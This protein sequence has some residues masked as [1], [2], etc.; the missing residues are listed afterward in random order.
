MFAISWL[1]SL[2]RFEESLFLE[3]LSLLICAGNCTR[4]RC[5]ATISCYE[6][7]FQRP[8]TTEFPVKF[9]V[10]RE[11]ARRQV[12]SALRRQ[13]S[14]PASG[15]ALKETRD[16]AGN[17]GFSRIRFRLQTPNSPIFGRELPKVSG[18]VRDYSRFAETAAGDRVRSRLPPDRTMSSN[19]SRSAGFAEVV[20]S[21]RED[22]GD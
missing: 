14:I 19:P 15:Q 2:F 4:C 5:G 10:C 16:R 18:H 20:D 7:R 13:P 3:I 9:P 12:R 8:E 6:I 17:A 22:V 1:F 21:L 11:F